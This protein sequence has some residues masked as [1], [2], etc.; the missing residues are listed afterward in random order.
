MKKG[1]LGPQLSVWIMQVSIFSS[2]YINR[3][4]C[5]LVLWA[6]VKALLVVEKKCYILFQDL[7][8]FNSLVFALIANITYTIVE[9]QYMLL[10][11][12][13]MSCN[14]LLLLQRYVAVSVKL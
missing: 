13:Y 3:F 10:P 6:V 9:K 4:H 12:T 1:R 2:V 11:P 8:I 14:D 5:S 7:E